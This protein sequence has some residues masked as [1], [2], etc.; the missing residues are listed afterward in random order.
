MNNIIELKNIS[1]IYRNGS[2]QVNALN[3]INLDVKMGEFCAIIG[4]SGSGKSTLMNILGC[5]DTPTGG[6]YLLNGSNVSLLSDRK[7][8]KIRSR[9]IGFIFQGFNLLTSLTAYENV[10]LPLIYRGIGAYDR[11]KL[12]T[13][14]LG[15]VGLAERL[16]HLPSQLS[17]GQQQRVAI[18]RAISSCPQLILADEPTGNLD[19]K[20]GNDVIALLKSLNKKGHTIILI[21]HDNSVAKQFERVISICDGVASEG[22]KDN[23]N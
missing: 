13:D 5:L 12:V 22:L 3:N 19:S 18:A 1:K 10:E 4:R 21:T 15:Q 14:A 9:E 2:Q 7:L 23:F 11:K 6:E 20:S 16:D 8:S 17:G